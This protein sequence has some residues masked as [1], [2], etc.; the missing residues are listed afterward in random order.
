MRSYY[1][2]LGNLYDGNAAS[3]GGRSNS[4]G[5]Y[6]PYRAVVLHIDYGNP[7]QFPTEN[8]HPLAKLRAADHSNEERRR[9]PNCHHGGVANIVL[10]KE[11]EF[12]T[13][14]QMANMPLLRCR[15]FLQDTGFFPS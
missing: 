9:K 8:W 2:C 7:R 14:V 5:A 4:T 15:A 13:K 11:E 10:W 6:L 1:T 12:F 3:G